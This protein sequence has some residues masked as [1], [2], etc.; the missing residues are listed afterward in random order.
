MSTLHLRK[1]QLVLTS[2]L[3][4]VR[5]LEDITA[6]QTQIE[7]TTERAQPIGSVVLSALQLLLHLRIWSRRPAQ[8]PTRE[9]HWISRLVKILELIPPDWLR[10][11]PPQRTAQ[12]P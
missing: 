7:R 1:R 2:D 9:S 11:R 4:R 5:L 3:C 6:L 8:D 10:R 12:G